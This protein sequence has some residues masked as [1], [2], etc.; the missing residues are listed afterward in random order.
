MRC[1]MFSEIFLTFARLGLE[2]VRA[3]NDEEAQHA[4]LMAA[5]ERIARQ[6]ALKKFGR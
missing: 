2:L 5:E 4:A 6:R 1:P 3:R